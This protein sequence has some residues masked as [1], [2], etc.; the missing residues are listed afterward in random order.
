M[1]V[2][3][4]SLTRDQTRVPCIGGRILNHCTTREVPGLDFKSCFLFYFVLNY[5][6]VIIFTIAF[7]VEAE[8]NGGDVVR[9]HANCTNNS[10]E[11]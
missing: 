5:L 4:S 10:L 6:T 3:S 9:S 7:L 2:G 11:L 1:H 8:R